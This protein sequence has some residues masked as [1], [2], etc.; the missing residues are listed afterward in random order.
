MK[1]PGG[2]LGVLWLSKRL[3][4]HFTFRYMLYGSSGGKPYVV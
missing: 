4:G 1:R 3:R 2:G